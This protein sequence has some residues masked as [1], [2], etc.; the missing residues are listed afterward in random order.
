MKVAVDIA[1]WQRRAEQYLLCGWTRPRWRRLQ[2]HQRASAGALT[3]TD[4][5]LLAEFVE[6][7]P[8]YSESETPL[9][10]WAVATGR[11]D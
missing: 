4:M 9:I 2:I 5:A 10:W 11:L 8:S 3:K 1:E 6:A 7:K